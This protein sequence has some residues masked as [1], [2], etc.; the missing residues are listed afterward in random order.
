MN[1]FRLTSLRA[2]FLSSGQVQAVLS[3]LRQKG[4]LPYIFALAVIGI[5]THHTWFTNLSIMTYGDCTVDYSEKAV[6]FMNYPQAWTNNAMGARDMVGVFWP[7]LFIFG[8]LA[9]LNFSPALIERIAYLW[10]IALLTPI[11][12]YCLS[13]YI[14]KSK[15]GA[16]TSAVVYTFN[17]P[18]IVWST[19][20]LT[21]HMAMTLTPLLLLT[22]F[23]A[24][25][26]ENFF[27]S[28]L[29][30]ILMF[31]IGFYDFRFLYLVV[32]ILFL[33]TVFH[34][35]VFRARENKISKKT[36][37][38]FAPL[39]VLPVLLNLY[40]LPSLFQPNFGGGMLSRDLFGTSFVDLAKSIFLFEYLWTGSE[41]VAFVVRPI[42]VLCLPIPF[43]A[44]LG[45]YYTKGKNKY[46]LF[47]SLISLAG[48][49]LTK[50]DHQPFS[51]IYSWL[52][53]NFP[54][55]NAFRDSTKFY[56][57]IALGYAVLIGAFAKY[58]SIM[59][60]LPFWKKA[61]RIGLIIFINAIF[62][63]NAKPLITGEIR[64]IYVPRDTPNDYLVLK[65]FLK[66]QDEF[67]RTLYI[68]RESRWGY[69]TNQHP[70]MSN[71]DFLYGGW[72]PLVVANDQISQALL[73]IFQHDISS[74]LLNISAVKYVI[75]PTRD[76]INDDDF[77]IYYGNSRIKYIQA[78]D[79]LSYLKRINI[80]TSEL[81]VYENKNYRPHIYLTTEIESLYKSPIHSNVDYECTQPTQCKVR[82]NNVKSSMFLNFA[83]NYD[84]GWK[85]LAG[86]VQ[87]N[88]LSSEK[89]ELPESFHIK[90]DASLNSFFLDIEYFKEHFPRN[91]HVNP[92]G[93]INL[94][95]TLYF[96]AQNAIKMGTA[97][98]VI[99]LFGLL[100]YIFSQVFIKINF[101]KNR[102]LDRSHTFGEQG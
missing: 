70:R 87:W 50:M 34:F 98:T 99:T 69:Y 91:Y 39:I 53:L 9:N 45:I 13:F 51:E 72:K 1:T 82:L 36:F 65:D 67:Y 66:Q 22:Y 83:E 60:P 29:A 10:P 38:M 102:N 94:E 48:I 21:A 3:Y 31:V 81:V 35:L 44:I 57:Y 92:D 41:M 37:L 76:A 5:L 52:Y 14:L 56:F 46:I 6:E 8:L 74:N 25:K 78:L 20:I 26:K 18:F 30:S 4:H 75:V 32:G 101:R 88:E 61:S 93:S 17:I 40:W 97:A 73:S 77:F 86:S 64:T 63:W 90:N 54:G 59:P 71:I 12:M 33:Y 95:L 28:V 19:G 49:F 16:F 96:E 11:C 42:S 24:L 68:P 100:L 2:I 58:L 62:L 43:L 7:L 84:S 23:I 85:M 89:N 27:Y 80:G 47:F 55:F 15:M 79:Q